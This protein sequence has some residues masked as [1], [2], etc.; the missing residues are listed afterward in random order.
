MVGKDWPLDLSDDAVSAFLARTVENKA[1][2][3]NEDMLSDL[4]SE[5]RLAI[6]L[7]ESFGPTTAT[8]LL[9]IGAGAGV[10]AAFLHHQGASITAIEP[11]TEG[12]KP[13]KEVHNE[14]AARVSMPDLLRISATE[15]N[16]AHHGTFDVVFSVNVI[17]HMNPLHANL[18]AMGSVVGV[19]GRM[20]HTCPN[21]RV[22]YEP[23]LHVPLVPGWPALTERLAPRVRRDPVWQTLNWVTAGDI[24]EFAQEHGFD[25]RFMPGQLAAAVGR[26]ADD[27]AFARR[28]NRIAAFVRMPGVARALGWLPPEWSTPMT[29]LLERPHA[30]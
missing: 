2:P 8:E 17:E 11:L 4:A 3:G 5:A 20:V 7:L 24:R 19:Q 9:E 23:H 10:V 22:P 18:K 14:L 28:Q 30:K 25:L 26:L 13:F 16:P 15:L 27:P 29:F 12:F 6:R 1:F 21:Y